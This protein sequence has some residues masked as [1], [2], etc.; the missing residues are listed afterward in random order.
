METHRR[1]EA[2][3]IAGAAQAR[4]NGARVLSPTDS[5]DNDLA[6]GSDLGILMP[7]LLEAPASTLTLFMLEWL[8]VETLRAA[9]A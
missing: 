2:S 3:R 7:L 6:A 4:L 9:N 5:N 8:A 1:R